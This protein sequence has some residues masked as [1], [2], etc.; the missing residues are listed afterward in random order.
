MQIIKQQIIFS[1]T[2]YLFDHPNIV[3]I[4]ISFEINP[5]AQTKARRHETN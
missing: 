4:E 1:L 3:K 2:T 5:L